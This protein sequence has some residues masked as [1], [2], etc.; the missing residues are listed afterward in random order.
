MT[1]V[2]GTYAGSYAATSCIVCLMFA[3]F[4]ARVLGTGVA[5]KRK[6]ASN[7]SAIRISDSLERNLN[8]AKHIELAVTERYG[9]QLVHQLKRKDKR[10]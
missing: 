10:A 4:L 2:G 3:G 9:E 6:R 5:E 8:L 1:R 7:A